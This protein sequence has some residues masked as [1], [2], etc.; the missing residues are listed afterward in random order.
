MATTTAPTSRLFCNHVRNSVSSSKSRTC[1]SVGG[2][3]N[4]NGEPLRL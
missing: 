3:L 2:S 4:Q 1:A